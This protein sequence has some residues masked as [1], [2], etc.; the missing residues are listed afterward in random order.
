MRRSLRETRKAGSLW[1]AGRAVPWLFN[2][3]FAGP[4]EGDRGQTF[5]TIPPSV[6]PEAGSLQLHLPLEV[7]AEDKLLNRKQIFKHKYTNRNGA[8]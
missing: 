3:G 7:L 8:V 2:T 5:L 4:A 6:E 1:A